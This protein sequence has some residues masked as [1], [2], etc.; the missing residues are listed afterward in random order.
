MFPPCYSHTHRS[1][2]GTNTCVRASRRLI[3]TLS[4]GR[5]P[6]HSRQY[7]IDTCYIKNNGLGINANRSIHGITP[8]SDRFLWQNI[9][10]LRTYTATKLTAK[11]STLDSASSTNTC[12]LLPDST[13]LW[14]G[15]AYPFNTHRWWYRSTPSGT[16]Y[17]S[18]EAVDY[19][20]LFHYPKSNSSRG[21]YTVRVLSEDS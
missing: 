8:A 19:G 15:C 2:V 16:I 20:I 13:N 9:R 14:R 1:L 7:Q 3:Q 18:V 4:S 12:T 11:Q 21:Y 5:R 10:L 17:S 6:D